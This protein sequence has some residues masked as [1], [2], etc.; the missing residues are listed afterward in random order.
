MKNIDIDID[1][2]IYID[3]K[4]LIFPVIFITCIL[5]FYM[6]KQLLNVNFPEDRTGLF[7]YLFGNDQN[8][9]LGNNMDFYKN[10]F[11]P[12]KK[13]VTNMIRLHAT[14]AIAMPIEIRLHVLASSKD[15]IHS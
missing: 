9:N 2:Q 5:A 10:Q 7:F 14:G 4:K 3:N 15:V 8:N 13:G 11:R 12:M 1:K 6:Q